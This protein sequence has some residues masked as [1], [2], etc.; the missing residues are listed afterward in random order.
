MKQTSLDTAQAM[1]RALVA[2]AS[3]ERIAAQHGVT[4]STVSQRVRQLAGELQRVVGV[5]GVDEETSPTAHLIRRYGADYLEALEHF[6]PTTAMAP[7]ALSGMVTPRQL[8]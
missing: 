6:V 8:V 1:L 3:C 4:E 5:L 7:D 2:G